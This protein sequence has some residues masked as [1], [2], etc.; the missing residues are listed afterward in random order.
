MLQQ[1][2]LMRGACPSPQPKSARCV[3]S[4]PNVDAYTAA[5]AAI[6]LPNDQHTT[7]IHLWRGLG[8][9]VTC[10]NLPGLCILK[11]VSRFRVMFDVFLW[12]LAKLWYMDLTLLLLQ[13]K[14]GFISV[15]AALCTWSLHA[16]PTE[17]HPSNLNW[18][19]NMTQT[20]TDI[21]HTESYVIIHLA[22]IGVWVLH[23]KSYCA[24]SHQSACKSERKCI[25]QNWRLGHWA[26]QKSQDFIAYF[27]AKRRSVSPEWVSACP[28]RDTD[29]EKFGIGKDTNK[30]ETICNSTVAIAMLKLCNVAGISS[31]DF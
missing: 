1:P 26:F 5:P 29:R 2:P 9:R 12:N 7:R 28:G 30:R 10:Q 14:Y 21:H 17:L 15:Y 3:A 4:H 8:R 24:H 16:I 23:L 31:E 13:W 11:R 25:P 20:E 6:D 18:K 22:F 19:L 27:Y